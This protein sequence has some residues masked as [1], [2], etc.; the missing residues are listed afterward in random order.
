MIAVPILRV[1][2]PTL[3]LERVAQMYIDG[4]GFE[5][6]ARFEDHDGFDGIVLGH[7]GGPY[8]LE[9]TRNRRDAPERQTSDERLLVYYLPDRGEWAARCL[10]MARAGFRNAR[11]A[12]PYWDAGGATFTDLDGSRIVLVN[13]RWPE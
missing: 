5:V 7:A 4:L 3:Q 11:S 10:R 6:L 1:A 8:H 9:F 13:A 2:R 12:N